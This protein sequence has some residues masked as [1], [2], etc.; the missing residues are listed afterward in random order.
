ME[1]HL[2]LPYTKS[3]ID[4]FNIYTR[5]PMNLNKTAVLFHSVHTPLKIELHIHIPLKIEN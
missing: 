2:S 5:L 1:D 3:T 4:I